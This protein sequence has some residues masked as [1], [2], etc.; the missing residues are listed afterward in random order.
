MELKLIQLNAEKLNWLN[1]FI[2]SYAGGLKSVD[3]SVVC[4]D[5]CKF[6]VAIDDKKEV[7]Y[8]RL[9]NYTGHFVKYT[10]HA[11]W[12]ICEAYVKPCYRSRGYLRLMI[13]ECVQK[14]NAGSMKIETTRLNMYWIYYYSLGFTYAYTVNDQLSLAFQ[15]KIETAARKR[16]EE[17][18]AANDDQYRTAA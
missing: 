13:E 12:H 17:W 11:V 4:G 16:N 10:D 6:F 7:G 14:H 3:L 18:L 15:T 2:K 1:R 8:I 9:T 5:S